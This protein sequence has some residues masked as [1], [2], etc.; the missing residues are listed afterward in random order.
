MPISHR[1]T[2][3]LFFL[4]AV[5]CSSCSPQSQR[6]LNRKNGKGN[7]PL[8]TPIFYPQTPGPSP[9]ILLLPQ[10]VH[11]IS[12]ENTIARNLDAE[13]YVARA[14]DYGDIKFI[15]IFNDAARMNSLKQLVSESLASLRSQPGVD[16]DRIGVVG[17]S[18]GGFF[19]TNL[20][21]NPNSVGLR[22]VVVYYGIYDVPDHIKNLGVPVLVFQGDEDFP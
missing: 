5:V 2:A 15:G 4:A 8:P 22:A 9:A 13:G 6:D 20:A 21:S 12:G 14:V 18:L 1:N 3:I 17:Y 7:I 11:D 10:A 16:P 19:A